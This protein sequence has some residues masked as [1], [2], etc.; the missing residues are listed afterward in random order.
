[1]Y[2]TPDDSYYYVTGTPITPLTLNKNGHS[3]D[4]TRQSNI[5][6]VAAT[7]SDGTS[8]E[9][10]IPGGLNS[11]TGVISGTP[12][13]TT[14]AR[15]F[16]IN[17]TD[18]D[19]NDRETLAQLQVQ[20]GVYAP[21]GYHYNYTSSSTAPSMTTFTLVDTQ[22]TKL[23][24]AN[25][26]IPGGS[27]TMTASSGF[28][29]SEFGFSSQDGSIVFTADA[30]KLSQSGSGDPVRVN[31]TF[32]PASGVNSTVG[33]ELFAVSSASQFSFMNGATRTPADG[34][35]FV[36]DT[37][38]TID[39][40]PASPSTPT[41]DI[42]NETLVTGL[43]GA[44]AGVTFSLEYYGTNW[45]SVFGGDVQAKAPHPTASAPSPLEISGTPHVTQSAS[46]SRSAPFYVSVWVKEGEPS[47]IANLTVSFGVYQQPVYFFSYGSFSSPAGQVNTFDFVSGQNVQLAIVSATPQSLDGS[48]QMVNASLSLLVGDVGDPS[49]H[50]DSS[51][52]NLSFTVANDISAFPLTLQITLSPSLGVSSSVNLSFSAYDASELL[53]AALVLCGTFRVCWRSCRVLVTVPIYTVRVLCR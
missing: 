37:Q 50:V 41:A 31:V 1:M 42:L 32:S 6:Y 14:A 35:Y 7:S 26:P 38:L 25:P 16:T 11:S 47:P 49:F 46:S 22:I 5:R 29:A 39:L 23:G 44:A 20:F 28:T 36:Q 3:A 15:A 10:Y 9:T 21:I 48:K 40:M 2:A 43:T 13:E 19:T 30:V 24:I 17:I 8:I 51:S 53:T 52:G 12:L 18:A 4:L 45:T 27:Y 33:L 34:S